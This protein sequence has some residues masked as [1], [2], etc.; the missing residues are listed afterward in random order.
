MNRQGT[1]YM[2]VSTTLARLSLAEQIRDRI[3]ARIMAGDLKPGDRLIELRIAAEMNTSQ[4]PVREAIRELEAIGLVESHR[5]RGSRVRIISDEELRDMYDV[6]A[7]LEGYAAELVARKQ[8]PIAG[9]LRA[10]VDAMKEAAEAK[11]SASFSQHNST[12]HR[13]IVEAAGNVILLGFWETLNVKART[14]I[15]VSRQKRDLGRIARSHEAIVEMI[16]AGKPTKAR[17]AASAHVLEN[18]PD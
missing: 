3:L 11:D 9:D 10:C 15:N 8:V 2:D 16:E 14:L 17:K 1:I 13:L 7:Q 18:K 5:N 12:F 6:R 4:A